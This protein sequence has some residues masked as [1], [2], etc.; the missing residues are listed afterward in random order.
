M[1]FA[2]FGTKQFCYL[3]N[4]LSCIHKKMQLSF[5]HVTSLSTKKT[6]IEKL[7]ISGQFSTCRP[8][9]K[10]DRHAMRRSKKCKSVIPHVINAEK[11]FSSISSHHLGYSQGQI[12]SFI[13]LFPVYFIS[14]KISLPVSF[15]FSTL[16]C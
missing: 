14:V 12:I 8:M 15:R 7:G 6:R 16:Y 13:Q 4:F 9:R 1:A 2:A 11:A 3:D 10:N 5:S